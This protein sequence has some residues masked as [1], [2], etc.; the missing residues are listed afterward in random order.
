M[1]GQ[2]LAQR[3]GGSGLW[4]LGS[5]VPL[6]VLQ[7]AAASLCQLNSVPSIPHI[8]LEPDLCAGPVIATDSICTDSICWVVRSRALEGGSHQGKAQR[9]LGQDFRMMTDLPYSPPQHIL[10][11]PRARCCA[12]GAME[13]GAQARKMNME[14]PRTPRLE[15]QSLTSHTCL[16]VCLPSR[17]VR[18]SLTKIYGANIPNIHQEENQ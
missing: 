3:P 2:N 6:T 14:L 13:G 1:P 7:P 8:F 16:S 12:R 5:H 10:A 11:P 9:A 18:L 17:I 4:E 15:M